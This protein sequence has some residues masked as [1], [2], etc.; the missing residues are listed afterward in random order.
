[1]GHGR[2]RREIDDRA[3]TPPGHHG[4]EC[5]RH[6][7][8]ADDVDVADGTHVVDRGGEQVLVDL[9]GRVVHEDAGLWGEVGDTR[10]RVGVR[11]IHDRCATAELRLE[12]AEGI[13]VDVEGEHVVAVGREALAHRPSDPLSRARDHCC[14]PAHASSVVGQS[15]HASPCTAQSMQRRSTSRYS[16]DSHATRS[17]TPRSSIP[18]SITSK[19]PRQW[20]S[21]K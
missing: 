11:H 12:H 2:D 16:R 6:E 15:S 14:S 4:N 21:V 20:P 17:T 13:G 7:H 5:L 19:R 10:D 3:P 1:M 9:D 18:R 8:R